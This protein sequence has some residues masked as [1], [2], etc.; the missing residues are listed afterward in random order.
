MKEYNSKCFKCVAE[1]QKDK[2]PAGAAGVLFAKMQQ[3]LAGSVEDEVF[4]C[5]RHR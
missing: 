3:N 5:Q 1:Q 2:K 4:V